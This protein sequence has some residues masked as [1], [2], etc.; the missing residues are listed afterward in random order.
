MEETTRATAIPQLLVGEDSRLSLYMRSESQT[1]IQ[2]QAKGFGFVRVVS[3][4]CE[5]WLLYRCE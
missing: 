5:T 1:T 2:L 4:P 3:W